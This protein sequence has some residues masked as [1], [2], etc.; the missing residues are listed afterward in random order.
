MYDA[1]GV[2]REV[3]IHAKTLNNLL[4]KTQQVNSTVSQDIDNVIDCQQGDSSKLKMDSLGP[5]PFSSTNVPPLLLNQ[6]KQML[7]SSVEE[8]S[9][10][11]G[12]INSAV[13]KESIGHT[14]VEV[15]A[16]CKELINKIGRECQGHKEHNHR[17]HRRQQHTG[18]CK[19]N[20]IGQRR[21]SFQRKMSVGLRLIN[22]RTRLRILL[23][24]EDLC[25]VLEKMKTSKT[26]VSLALASY[27]IY[28]NVLRTRSLFF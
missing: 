4:S 3:G 16:G 15:I 24:K 11:S 9:E 2:R 13:L 28:I 10:R 26:W 27:L 20:R 1:Q 23:A 19:S 21:T 7:M 12:D 5:T 25:L 22:F 6:T 8:G 17:D 18:Q 14:E